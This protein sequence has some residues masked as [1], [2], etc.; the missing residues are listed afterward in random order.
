MD[1]EEMRETLRTG[2]KKVKEPFIIALLRMVFS[3]LMIVAVLVAIQCY[4]IYM[5]INWVDD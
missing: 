5:A 1:T 2:V 4:L 3:R